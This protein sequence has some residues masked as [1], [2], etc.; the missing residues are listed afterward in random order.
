MMR[1]RTTA[2]A[3]QFTGGGAGAM[4][5]FGSGS[6]GSLPAAAAPRA[7]PRWP[8]PPPPPPEPEQ[9]PPWGAPTWAFLH[10]LAE[11]VHDW[12]FAAHRDALLHVVRL[13]ADNL[14]CPDC[15]AHARAFL[16]RADLR[17]L[18]TKDHL[19]RFLCDFH[20]AV[21]F[22][23]GYPPFDPLALGDHYAAHDFPRAAARFLRAFDGGPAN[24]GL[25][26]H[27]GSFQRRLAARALRDWCAA[28]AHLFAPPPP[29]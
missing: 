26:L 29:N 5:S 14:P 28:H 19:R 1:R 2:T 25:P 21:N 18:L 24:G 17:F 16:A 6:F 12:A 27:A 10:T 20:N 8:P 23:K 9:K 15:A 3:M 7:P 13:V 22:R 11:R 4:G